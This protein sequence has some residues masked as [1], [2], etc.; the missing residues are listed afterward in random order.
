[1]LVAGLLAGLVATVIGLSGVTGIELIGGKNL[2]CLVWSCPDDTD[3]SGSSRSSGLSIFGGYPGTGTQGTPSGEQQNT[4]GS[5]QQT[6]Q[7]PAGQPAQPGGGVD[8]PGGI[9]QGENPAQPGAGPET[10]E[11]EPATPADQ[12]SEKGRGQGPEDE[13]E[14]ED[15]G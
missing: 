1:V 6:P 2:S 3:S 13:H 9:P 12:G 4:P 5:G 8:Q 14:K 7:Q 11:A 15:R 10:D